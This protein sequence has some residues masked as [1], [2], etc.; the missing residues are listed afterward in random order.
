MI[1]LSVPAVGPEECDLLAECIETGWIA[2]GPMVSEF[3]DRLR[4]ITGAEHAVACS[5]GT[6]ALHVALLCA[7]VQCGDLVVVPSITFIATANAVRYTGADPLLAECDEFLGIDAPTLERLFRD[8]CSF[9]GATC[10]HSATGRRISAVIPV[11]VFGTPVD[12]AV[13][14][15]CAE[16]GVLVVEDAA[17][18]LGSY[19]D[20][21]SLRGCH[22]GTVGAAGVVSFNANK[23]VTSAGG[24]AIL[25]ADAGIAALARRYINQFKSDDGSHLHERVGYNYRTSGLH[26]AVGLAQLSKL[27]AFVDGRRRRFELYSDGLSQV[28]G[29]A[30]IPERPGT[31]SNYWLPC[32]TVDASEFGADALALIDLLMR[33]GIETRL[34]WPPVHTQEAYA[35]HLK[36]ELARVESFDGRVL[37]LPSSNG[38]TDEDATRVVEA[39]VRVHGEP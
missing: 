2:G 8:E 23:I 24:G 22:T 27:D 28:P 7:G 20:S 36:T 12:P 25:T 17:E 39:I 32:A 33:E 5:S 11:H 37:N 1:P 26:A 19:W 18:S 38:M 9:D 14:E 29:V 35:G 3:E 15:I 30:L 10:T 31:F 6:A 13:F 16:H 34:M 4:A 21:G